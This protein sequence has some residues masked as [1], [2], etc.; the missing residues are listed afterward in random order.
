MGEIKSLREAAAVVKQEA[1]VD[2]T[3]TL[4]ELIRQQE[5]TQIAVTGARNSGKT[6]FINES[7]GRE[8][9]E[10]GTFDEDEKTLRISFE[11]LPEDENFNCLFV[12]D[13]SWRAYKSV[14]YEMRGNILFNDNALADDMYK[15]DMVFFIISATSPF[16]KDDVDALKA[17]A[18]LKRQVV[19]NGMHHVKDAD[20]DKV[21]NYISKVNASL[22]LPPVII[23][24][25]GKNFGQAVRNLLPAYV[26]LKEWREEKCRWLVQKM[27][28]TLEQTVRNEID[29][30]AEFERQSVKT[31]SI[32][33]DELR[34]S[35]YTLRTDVGDYKKAAIEAVT[36]K[37]S[38]RR[39]SLINEILDTAK[40][41]KD[42][43]KIQSVAEEKYK[44]LSTA[45]VESLEKIFL[46]DLRNVDSAAR[47]LSVPQWTAETFNQL[48]NFSP[49]NILNQILLEKLTVRSTSTG[50]DAP[51]LIGSGLV[52]G[53]L[54]LAPILSPN[55]APLP[56]VVSVGGAV[57]ALGYAVVSHMKNKER[58]TREELNALDDAI[59]Q[60]IDNIKDFANNI[61]D[62]SYGKISEQILIGEDAL[63]N[64]PTAKNESRLA[65]LND[66]LNAINQMKA[67]LE[68]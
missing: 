62:I 68:T 39:E 9:W 4:V 8:V 24:E 42:S 19:V 57:V 2:K 27:F 61:A 31:L 36:G 59:R 40:Q 21:L 10:P 45:A 25:S 11:P 6:T 1:L 16:G 33:N 63:S 47:L 65:Q 56:P 52:A 48:K 54:T 64:P 20:R 66:I 43:D 29:T 7:I 58:K 46:E 53:G 34:S 3:A 35:C 17:L 13:P 22:E 32:Q 41:M 23:L 12:S 14:L 30:A 5:F 60:A 44:A 49:Q 67:K 26:E 28:D 18:P 15:L 55:L 37:L 38:S 51:I 50:N